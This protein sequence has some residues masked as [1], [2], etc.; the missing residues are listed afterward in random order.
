MS[1][2]HLSTDKTSP[3]QVELASCNT[4]KYG[5]LTME[6]AY[7]NHKP[8]DPA[9]VAKAKAYVRHE[10]EPPDNIEHLI[11]SLLLERYFS[12]VKIRTLTNQLQET[13]EAMDRFIEREGRE[14]NRLTRNQPVK[15]ANAKSA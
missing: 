12:D 15:M 7:L 3:A 10:S 5:V 14:I 4:P 1:K 6:K 13:M 9:Q 8:N 11:D 2:T